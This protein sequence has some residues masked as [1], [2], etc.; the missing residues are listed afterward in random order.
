MRIESYDYINGQSLGQPDSLSFGDLIQNQHSIK[1]VV[2]RFFSDLTDSTDISNVRLKL[3]NKGA[4]SDTEYGFYQSPSFT[5][6]E[7]GSSLFTHFSDSTMNLTW[8]GSSTGFIWLDANI[9][10]NTGISEAGFKLLYDTP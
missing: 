6:I 8:D 5:R 2:I 4:W 7:S 9:K 1:P 3:E 10:Q